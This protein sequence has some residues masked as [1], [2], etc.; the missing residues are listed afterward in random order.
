M[1]EQLR[2]PNLVHVHH[3]SLYNLKMIMEARLRVRGSE[4]FPAYPYV[5]SQSADS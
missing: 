4:R 1:S 2:G 5:F 3:G